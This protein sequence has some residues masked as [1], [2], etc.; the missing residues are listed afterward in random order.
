[1]SKRDALV[2]DFEY[3][4]G[5]LT[6]TLA[7]KGTSWGDEVYIDVARDPELAGLIKRIG[8]IVLARKETAGEDNCGQCTGNC[9]TANAWSHINLTQEDVDRLVRHLNDGDTSGWLEN[10]DNSDVLSDQVYAFKFKDADIQGGKCCPFL[11]V[12]DGVGRCSVYEARPRV[13]RE[14]PAWNCHSFIPISSLVR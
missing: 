8:E 11:D 4:R 13:C 9:C 7:E 2:T 10:F 6:A 5:F 3:E 1:M 12:K 14:F